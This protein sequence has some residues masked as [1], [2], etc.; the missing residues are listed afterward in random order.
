VGIA[1]VAALVLA[2]ML[3]PSTLAAL[4]EPADRE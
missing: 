3:H 4:E 1:V 2:G